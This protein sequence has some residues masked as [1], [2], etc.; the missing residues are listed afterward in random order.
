ME[1]IVVFSTAEK[2][3]TT[4]EPN[5]ATDRKPNAVDRNK[6]HDTKF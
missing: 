5:L 6:G 2:L 1:G 3:Q 4:I